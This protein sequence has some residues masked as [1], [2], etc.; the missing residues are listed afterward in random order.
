MY[1]LNLSLLQFALVFGAISAV[2]FAL[3]LLDRSRRRVTVSSLAFWAEAV[4]PAAAAHRKRIHQPWSLIL[5]LLSIALLLL[6]IAQ[7]RIG[8]RVAPGHD[9]VLLLDTSAWMSARTANGSLMDEARRQALA[10]VRAAPAADRIMVV[11]ADAVATPATGFESD[12]ETLQEAI[13]NSNPGVTALDLRQAFAFARHIQSQSGRSPGEVVFAGAGRVATDA[14][15]TAASLPPNLRVLPVAD[16]AENCGL[17]KTGARRSAKDS[18]AWEVSAS[19]RNYGP[20]ARSVTVRLSDPAHSSAAQDAVEQRITI[21]PE[22]EKEVSFLH[23]SAEASR[24]RIEIAPHD[25][26]PADDSAELDLPAQPVLRTTV[27][28]LEP[29]LLKPVLASNEGIMAEYRKPSEY[30][31]DDPGLVVLDRFIPTVRPKSDSIWIDPPAEGSPA[32]VIQT[33][34]NARITRW[35]SVHP[36][37]SGLR[38]RDFKLQKTSIFALAP[39]DAAIGETESGPAIVALAGAPRAVVFG[40]HPG[41]PGPRYELATPLLFANIQ[42]WISPEMF[43]AWEIGGGALGVTKVALRDGVAPADV[44]VTDARGAQMPFTVRN[45]ELRFFA[46][47]P[48]TVRVRAKNDEYAYSLTLPQMW[49]AKWEPP[50]GTPRG[51][52]SFKPVFDSS[53]DI[54]PWLAALGG[55]GL[56]AEWLIFGAGRAAGRRAMS[57]RL[58]SPRAH[59]ANAVG[60]KP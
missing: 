36:I 27:Y 55:L 26:F 53:F 10:Y 42:R 25:R 38:T 22:T 39:G 43:R 9:H 5:Q 34:V 24:V 3:Y 41:A 8:A 33:A 12:R 2:A 16:S 57:V 46:A 40:F 21:P 7:L 20:E 49:D 35:S 32:R 29:D 48:G 13:S 15:E 1:L 56:L 31:A 44:R 37:A 47:T 51:L 4:Q 52:P 6:A 11:R 14:S 54:W 28:T 18:A 19:V 50:V 45:G 58:R 23:R 30:R 60:S 59:T 17:R